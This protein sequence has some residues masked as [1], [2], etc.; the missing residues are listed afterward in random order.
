MAVRPHHRIS[1]WW[2][3][4]ARRDMLILMGVGCHLIEYRRQL[5]QIN[6]GVNSNVDAGLSGCCSRT[7]LME[8]ACTQHCRWRKWLSMRAKIIKS[9]SQIWEQRAHAALRRGW[10][11]D[12]PI[13]IASNTSFVSPG[14]I[15]V[16]PPEID[17]APPRPGDWWINHH[18]NN[19][20]GI[21]ASR[22]TS[23]AV[24]CASQNA[25]SF[26]QRYA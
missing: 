2:R 4:K 1:L 7:S 23:P 21:M 17:F 26:S 13:P 10:T 16:E 24:C 22:R 11:S 8:T 15:P 18:D 19:S 12:H 9:L 5:E 25:V 6:E 20:N 14:P 3:E